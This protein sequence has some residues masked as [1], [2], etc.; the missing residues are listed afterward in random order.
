M[1]EKN[2]SLL[3]GLLTVTVVAVIVFFVIFFFFPDTSYKYFG[4]AFDSSKA[5]ENIFA[6]VI[7]RADYMT[8][9][10]TEK[11][12]EYLS[13]VDGRAFLKSFAS[14]V[15]DGTEALRNF[16]SSDSFEN[17]RETMSECLSPESLKKLSD[18]I[19]STASSL[20]K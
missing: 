12:S 15:T 9:E 4:T 1:A 6:S 16:T 11:V 13:S 18:T 19:N 8:E 17:F 2:V 20:L 14:A 5:V 7:Y 10:E 3:K